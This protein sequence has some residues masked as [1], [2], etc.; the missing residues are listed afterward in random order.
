M[1][2]HKKKKNAKQNKL[3]K[4]GWYVLIK[5]TNIRKQDSIRESSKNDANKRQQTRT[6]NIEQLKTNV[7][8]IV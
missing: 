8:R 3:H 5:N 4:S 6:T 2:T 1:Y 7:I